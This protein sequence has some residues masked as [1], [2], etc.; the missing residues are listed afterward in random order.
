[1]PLACSTDIF[2]MDSSPSTPADYEPLVLS[3]G[4]LLELAAARKACGKV[5]RA[6]RVA[7]LS[8]W[9]IALFAGGTLIVGLSTRAGTWMGL[10][11]I[12][13]AFIELRARSRLQ[14]LDPSAARTLGYNQ[15][16]LGF[17]IVM[18][19]GWNLDA[20]ILASP[21]PLSISFLSSDMTFRF[22]PNTAPFVQNVRLL[23]YGSMAVI[24][25]LTQGTAAWYYFSRDK[26]I[27]EYI[28][29]TPAWILQVQRAGVGL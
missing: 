19:A 21:Q 7:A 12:I 3:G 16:V 18:Y 6:V 4:Q 17:L 27:R 20:I 26:W 22:A 5:R 28:S 15:L 25:L 11:M 23:L 1:M 13:T 2:R 9:A 24:A 14:R 10:L 8:G 29:Q